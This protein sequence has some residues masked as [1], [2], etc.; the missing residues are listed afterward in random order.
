M[1][2]RYDQAAADPAVAACKHYA[3]TPHAT[4][5]GWSVVSAIQQS[6][7]CL[8]PCCCHCTQRA[9]PASWRAAGPD[10]WAL[11]AGHTVAGGQGAPDQRALQAALHDQVGPEPDPHGHR[12]EPAAAA[13][14]I[15]ALSTPRQRCYLCGRVTAAQ[16][17]DAATHQLFVLQAHC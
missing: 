8:P 10:V 7:W 16:L 4:C 5:V 12:W 1:A 2:T 13:A 17:V 6:S 14:A 9:W 15:A 11:W 3:W